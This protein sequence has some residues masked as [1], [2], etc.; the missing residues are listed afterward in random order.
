MDT[1]FSM[2]VFCQVVQSGSFTRA[3]QLLDISIPMASK[4]VAHLEKNLGI[5]LLYRNNRTL[6]L[7]EQGETYFQNCLAAL[8][9]LDQAA[10]E[11]TAMN[12]AKP[13]GTLR[14]SAPIW[15][16]CDKFAA[17]VT[18]YQQLYPQVELVISLTNRRVDL[19]SDGE[20][21]A[22]RLTHTLA[23]NVIAKPLGKIPFYLVASPSY[24]AEHGIPQTPE[25]FNEMQA[26]LP[27]YTDMTHEQIQSPHG[28]A[29]LNLAGKTRSDNTLMIASLIRAGSGIGYMPSW[30]AEEDLDSGKLVRLLPDYVLRTPPLYAVYASRRS[31]NSRLRSFIDFISQKC[32]EEHIY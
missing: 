7:T 28:F 5:Q 14:I 19:N 17:W 13:R 24:L 1:Y 18:E 12:S 32:E 30:L 2:K 8:E 16:A 21:L 20:D 6:K 11:A 10:D 26:V 3:A 15:F 23:E 29:T 9:I 25:A 22:L 31:M 4:H 27:T